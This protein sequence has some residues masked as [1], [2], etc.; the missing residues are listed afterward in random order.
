MRLFAAVL[1]PPVVLDHLERS[2]EVARATHPDLGAWGSLR[3]T[4]PQGRHLTLAFFGSTPQGYLPDLCEGLTAVADG[5]PRL[6]LALHG[7]GLFDRRTLWVGCTGDTEGLSG[8]M[9]RVTGVGEALL[10]HV[11]PRVRSRAHLTVARVRSRARPAVRPRLGRTAPA[12]D[13][14]ADL[15]R[16]LAV[17]TGPSWVVDTIA[18]IASEPGAGPGGHPVHEVLHRLPLRAVAG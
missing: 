1:P 14:I 11:D 9:G 7:A 10:G 12:S 18:L 8:L 16:A 6:S 15:A 3:W 2:L 13:G 17:Y 4:P 5:T